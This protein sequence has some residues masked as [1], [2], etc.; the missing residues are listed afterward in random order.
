M[1]FRVFILALRGIL[2]FKGI[3]VLGV[4]KVAEIAPEGA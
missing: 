4:E 2:V 1:V 3:G